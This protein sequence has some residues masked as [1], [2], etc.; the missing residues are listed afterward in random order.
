MKR[1]GSRA[2]VFVLL[3][4]RRREGETPIR[5]VKLI[6]KHVLKVSPPFLPSCSRLLGLRLGDCRA[7]LP[8]PFLLPVYASCLLLRAY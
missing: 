5:D 4:P 1:W 2:D 6:A 7:S 8:A 3:G